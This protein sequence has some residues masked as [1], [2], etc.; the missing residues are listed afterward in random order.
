MQ[1]AKIRLAAFAF[2]SGNG[3]LNL[4]DKIPTKTGQILRVSAQEK[5]CRKTTVLLDEMNKAGVD[6]IVFSS[7]AATY[8]EPDEI[9]IKE[10]TSQKPINP[11]GKSKLMIENILRDGIL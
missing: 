3:A 7:T 9:P 10:T 1:Q 5:V 4:V 8:G 11:Y 2:C 6:K